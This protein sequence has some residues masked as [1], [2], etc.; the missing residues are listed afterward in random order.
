M[1][2][3]IG[4]ILQW[5]TTYFQKHEIET[6]RLDAEL[7]LAFSLRCSRLSLYTNFDQPLQPLER[8]QY[9]E[10]IRR[11]AQKREPIAY[12]TGEKEFYSLPFCVNNAVLIP[13]PE[14]ETIVDTALEILNNLQSRGDGDIRVIDV[15]TGS[16]TIIVSLAKNFSG[17]RYFATDI[18]AKAIQ[19]ARLNAEKNGLSQ[20]IFFSQSD[21]FPD[22]K[23]DFPSDFHLICSNPPY[24]KRGLLSGLPPEIK[25][26]EPLLALDGGE[27][28]GDVYR[29]LATSSFKKLVKN[30]ILLV[31]VGDK[32]QASAVAEIF[33]QS[34]YYHRIRSIKDLAGHDRVVLAE[35][36]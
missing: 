7:L 32:E 17:A 16:G 8:S 12:I 15:G 20:K 18:S 30:G 6:P 1:E 23:A 24:I 21:L 31:E 35:R 5:T 11:R 28:G 19:I 2:W 4:Q 22:E 26:H 10:L 13:R 9:R 34:Q 25:N 3:T 36:T 27:D 33:E 29:R 14:T